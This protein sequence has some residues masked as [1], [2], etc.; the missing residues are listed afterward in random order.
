MIVLKRHR[1]FRKQNFMCTVILTGHR[2]ISEG[3][4]LTMI[5]FRYFGQFFIFIPSKKEKQIRNT[6]VILVSESLL[7]KQKDLT[8]EVGKQ[9][10]RNTLNPIKEGQHSHSKER[11]KLKILLNSLLRNRI[12]IVSPTV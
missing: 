12:W 8:N 1:N 5:P 2:F 4:V 10:T 7:K 11:K 6:M 9:N 3:F